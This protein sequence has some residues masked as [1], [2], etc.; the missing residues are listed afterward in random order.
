MMS[1]EKFY[2]RNEVVMNMCDA[3]FSTE[4]G[5]VS[6]YSR[7]K[8]KLDRTI[9][10]YRIRLFEKRKILVLEFHSV[11][12][13]NEHSCLPIKRGGINKRARY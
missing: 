1:L 9:T 10:Y 12:G 2:R 4:Y 6:F 13:K 3:I 11:A 5:E 8:F 7:R